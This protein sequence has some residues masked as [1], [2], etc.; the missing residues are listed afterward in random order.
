M[1][2][3]ITGGSGFIG[4][5]IAKMHLAKNDPVWVI[6]QLSTGTKANIAPYIKHPLFRFDEGNL[7]EWEKLPEAVAWADAIYHM[8]AVVGQLVVLQ[9]PVRVLTENIEGCAHLLRSMQRF[10]PTCPLLIASSSEVYR[11]TP[12]STFKEDSPLE[13]PSGENAHLNYPLSKFVNEATGLSYVEEHSIKCVIAR[14]FNTA[15]P[16]QTGSYGMVVPR[17]VAAALS[18]RAIEV[19]GDGSQTRAFCHVSN[20]VS[21]LERLLFHPNSSGEI[22]NVGQDKEISILALAQLVKKITASDSPIVF[23]P[24]EEAYGM[25]FEDTMRRRP[26]LTKLYSYLPDLKFHSLEEIITDIIQSVKV[27]I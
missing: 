5:H 6:D 20:T 17:F 12:H 13:F 21:I 23:V 1:K 11:F 9:N 27:S 16:R 19:F 26:D 18:G 24:Y 8:A 14:L 15:G 7:L 4:S 3:L 22:F 2:I 25:A 10:H